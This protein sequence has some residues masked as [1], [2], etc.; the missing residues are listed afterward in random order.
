M[1][2][3]CPGFFEEI[4]SGYRRGYMYNPVIEPAYVS[5]GTEAE[6]LLE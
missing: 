1:V 2:L 4:M 5:K 6:L 3:E